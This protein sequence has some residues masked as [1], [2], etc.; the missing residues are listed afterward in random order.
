MC[1]GHAPDFFLSLCALT[2]PMIASP[3]LARAAHS[4]RPIPRQVGLTDL[5]SVSEL[6][7]VQRRALC[8]LYR[9]LAELKGVDAANPSEAAELKARAAMEGVGLVIDL[10]PAGGVPWS[11]LP[12]SSSSSS[13]S[14]GGS[15]SAE[16]SATLALANAAES[17]IGA[18]FGAESPD[19]DEDRVRED[20]EEVVTVA[21]PPPPPPPPRLPPSPRPPL[22]YV[23]LLRGLFD[24][25]R[26][27]ALALMGGGGGDL[28]KG[29]AVRR[30]PQ[31]V[32]PVLRMVANLRGICAHLVRRF[33][34]FPRKRQ[35]KNFFARCASCVFPCSR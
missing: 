6:D 25:Q 15:L 13:S 2:D 17:V 32:A 16:E 24:T 29:M 10:P 5:S 3:H 33:D 31:A 8:R 12:L 35:Q 28:L 30:L 14:A 20:G 21:A 4:N 23:M 34:N 1:V 19:D 26:D 9:A 7:D 27:E 22:T 18:T 11:S